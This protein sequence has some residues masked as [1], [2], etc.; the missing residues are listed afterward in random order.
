MPTRLLK[1][2]KGAKIESCKGDGVNRVVCMLGD[3][4]ISHL[5]AFKR[6]KKAIAN[7]KKIDIGDSRSGSSDLL[8]DQLSIFS[9]EID[10]NMLIKFPC[11]YDKSSHTS[12]IETGV[13]QGMLWW[14]L[15]KK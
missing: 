11:L 14:K 9:I 8:L 5:I 1:T 15:P 3:N 6:L 7:V 2:I 4:L 12:R 13:L 10:F